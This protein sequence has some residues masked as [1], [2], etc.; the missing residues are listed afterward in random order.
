MATPSDNEGSMRDRVEAVIELIRPAVQADGGDVEL[1]GVSDA[2]V[3]QIRFLGQ[4]VTCPASNMTLEHTIAANLKSR[5]PEVT[6]V[7]PI[8]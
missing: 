5:V 6:E 8:A 3:V 2:G 1:V 7:V 4:C